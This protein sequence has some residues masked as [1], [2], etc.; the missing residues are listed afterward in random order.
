ML[1]K[2]V[3]SILVVVQIPMAA[4]VL[5]L[6]ALSLAA[7][8]WRRA[9]APAPARARF[10]ILIP[11]HDEELLLAH[12]LESLAALEYPRALYSVHVVADNCADGTAA[13]ATA[14]GAAM[15][16]RRD[17]SRRGKGY[18]LRYL[19]ERL[20]EGGVDVDAYIVVD[21]D[22][23]V[24][25]TFLAAMNR[26]LARGDEV[27]Q[28]YYGVLNSD[29][30]WPAALRYVALALYNGLRPRGRDA[31]RLSTGLRGNGMCFAAAILDRFGWDAFSLAEDAEFHLRLVEEGLKVSYAPEAIVLA[32]MPSSLRA[33]RSQNVRWE[34]GRLQLLRRFGPRLL[35]D[36]LRRRD[37]VRLDAVAEQLVPPLSLLTGLAT[38]TFAVAVALRAR[39][40]RRLATAIA[41]GQVLYV[42]IGLRLVDANAR[43]YAALLFSPLYV[44]W[45][46]GVYIAAATGLGDTRWVRTARARRKE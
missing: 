24:S 32:E 28:A 2:L 1:M 35:A 18:A 37:F 16:E 41:L 7:L 6:D 3:R 4:L 5:Y 12:L 42:I 13:A 8:L 39:A 27:I 40:A 44:M 34:R 25:P 30:S 11:A 38:L 9:P 43:T 23:V 21:A 26:R 20:R 14:G 36:G 10:A 45:K 19:F 17:E 15:Y 31:L 33:S 46:I 22:S 29:E